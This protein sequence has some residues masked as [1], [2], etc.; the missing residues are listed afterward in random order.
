MTS[1][2]LLP[3]PAASG[4]TRKKGAVG[5]VMRVNSVAEI[6]EVELLPIDGKRYQR[7]NLEILIFPLSQP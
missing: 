5:V 4:T 6:Q 3:H 7:G 2:N 1:N